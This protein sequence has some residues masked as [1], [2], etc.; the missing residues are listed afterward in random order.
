MPDGFPALAI[1][2]SRLSRLGYGIAV[3]ILGYGGVGM[4]FGV[5][6]GEAAERGQVALIGLAFLAGAAI[7]LVWFVRMFAAGTDP[8][9]IIDRNGIW[10][11]RLTKA[12]IAWTAIT[13]IEGI[14]PGFMERLLMPGSQAGKIILHIAPEARPGLEMANI[15]AGPLHEWLFAGSGRLRIFHGAI[16]ARFPYLMDA[17]LD[18]HDAAIGKSDDHLS[19][20]SA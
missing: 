18:A 16:D 7:C 4:V 14:A 8:V 6:G 9:L 19:T 20:P 17:L 15:Y 11:R 3:L 13:R 10:D 12:P 5:I 1:P 2:Y